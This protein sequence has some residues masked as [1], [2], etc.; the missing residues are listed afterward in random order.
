MSLRPSSCGDEEYGAVAV[1]GA[2]GVSTTALAWFDRWLHGKKTTL[3]DAPSVRYFRM[4]EN[5][6]HEVDTWPPEGG[7]NKALPA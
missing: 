5:R 1:G 6:W 7:A 4:V 2:A 3:V